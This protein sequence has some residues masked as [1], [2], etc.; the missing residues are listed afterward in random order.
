MA[1]GGDRPATPERFR[2]WHGPIDQPRITEARVSPVGHR[3]FFPKDLDA[4]RNRGYGPTNR[5]M[6]AGRPAVIPTRRVPLAG[7]GRHACRIST[8][9]PSARS[10]ARCRQKVLVGRARLSPSES[11]PTVDSRSNSGFL[12]FSSAMSVFRNAL[13]SGVSRALAPGSPSTRRLLP[14]GPAIEQPYQPGSLFSLVKSFG[15]VPRSRPKAN[16]GQWLRLASGPVTV[17]RS[18]RGGRPGRVGELVH[19]GI[20]RVPATAG[21]DGTARITR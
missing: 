2:A 21:V 20:F 6:T 11:S 13:G 8:A 16:E 9:R 7:R 18:S 5:D 14:S 3:A 10:C 15:A 12:S 1:A 19:R 17:R 4:L